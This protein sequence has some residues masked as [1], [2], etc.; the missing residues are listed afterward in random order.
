MPWHAIP[1]QRKER[2]CANSFS[3]S[4]TPQEPAATSFLAEA[5]AAEQVACRL[6]LGCCVD[7]VAVSPTAL[8]K[9]TTA[10]L[11]AEKRQRQPGMRSQGRGNKDSSS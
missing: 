6:D 9:R 4:Q 1:L 3:Q 5:M 8:D 7:H 11:L 2:S 10:A